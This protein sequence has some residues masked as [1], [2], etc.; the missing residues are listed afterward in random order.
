M[1]LAQALVLLP[2]LG[3]LAQLE[4][5]AQRIERRTPE[6]AIGISAC[7]QDEAFRLLAGIAGALIGDVGGGRRALEQRL[8]LLV[9]AGTDAQNHAGE[10]QPVGAIMGCDDDDLPENLQPAAEVAALEG[11]V[12]LSP[13]RGERLGHRAGFGLDPLK[14]GLE[15]DKQGLSLVVRYGN[16]KLVKELQAAGTAAKP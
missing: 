6:R 15:P 10:T 8:A 9:G 4:R 12:G 2:H 1:L 7:D 3:D 11:V 5:D 13:Q 14:V 16:R